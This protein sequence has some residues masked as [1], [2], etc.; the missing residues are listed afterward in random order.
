MKNT[1]LV[2]EMLIFKGKD[3]DLVLE[4]LIL[5][6]FHSFAWSHQLVVFQFW[7]LQFNIG[8]YGIRVRSPR[9]FS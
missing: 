6:L 1:D 7:D 2:L 3:T 8:V 9:W 5:F 4:M